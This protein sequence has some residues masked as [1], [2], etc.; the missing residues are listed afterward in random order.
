MNNQY[1]IFTPEQEQAIYKIAQKHQQDYDTLV[2]CIA[3]YIKVNRE[4]LGLPIYLH[5]PVSTKLKKEEGDGIIYK[6]SDEI[7]DV[8][9]TVRIKDYINRK[10]NKVTGVLLCFE[11]TGQHG[12]LHLPNMTVTEIKKMMLDAGVKIP[13]YKEYKNAN[14]NKS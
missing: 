5:L 1:S 8:S 6:Q 11:S 7:V 4:Q 2:M 3:D 13:S 9:T 12:N 10:T 14:Q